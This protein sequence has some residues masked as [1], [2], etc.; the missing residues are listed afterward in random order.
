MYHCLKNV[1]LSTGEKMPCDNTQF[2]SY[3]ELKTI[4]KCL[5]LMYIYLYHEALGN[6]SKHEERKNQGN[7]SLSTSGLEIYKTRLC[8]S[9][10][11]LTTN[12]CYPWVPL[13][14]GYEHQDSI[15]QPGSPAPAG[16][17]PGLST[18]WAI[19]LVP[20]ASI[21]LSHLLLGLV[22]PSW[23]FQ[24]LWAWPILIGVCSIPPRLY[25]QP[26]LTS[27]WF[28]PSCLTIP[29][30]NWAVD[31]LLMWK[32]IQLQ[33][34]SPIYFPV[35]T[36][37]VK[38]PDPCTDPWMSYAMHIPNFVSQKSPSCK[39]DPVQGSA[40]KKP[41]LA[42]QSDNQPRLWTSV[43]TACISDSSSRSHKTTV[44]KK[45]SSMSGTHTGCLV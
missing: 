20:A 27:C 32:K 45:V 14:G 36:L 22:M 38:Q 42:S 33:P 39:M 10:I 24:H 29:L 34:T 16:K 28:N 31:S 13:P 11:S 6:G 40:L 21:P 12:V 37:Y 8:A 7:P 4:I 41:S 3:S 19:L 18:H 2:S 43:L 5:T 25:V 30:L 17:T 9:H 35:R 44:P 1:F 15:H 26:D 23:S